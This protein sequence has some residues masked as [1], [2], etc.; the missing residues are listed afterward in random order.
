[1]SAQ[2]PHFSALGRALVQQG[3]LVQADANAI[4]AEAAK[5]GLSFIQQ[6]IQSKKLSAKDVSLFAAQ[7]FGYPLLDLN[8]V[9]VEQLPANLIDA[10]IVTNRRIIPLG[11]RGN[12]VFVGMSDPSNEQV[13]QEVKF[14]TG[15]TMEPIVVEDDKLAVMVRKLTESSA[16]KQID[17]ATEDVDL[18]G[19]EVTDGEAPASEVTTEEIDDAPVVKYVQKI[20]LDAILGGASDIHWEPYEKFYRIRYRTDGI[21]YEIAQPPLAI[22][23]KIASRIKVVSKMDISE[24]R[25]PQDGRMKMVLSKTRAIDFRVSTLPTLFG[26]KIVMRILDPSSATL[27]IDALGY[28]PDQK[29]TC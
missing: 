21:L 16:S 2:P 11:K 27:G 22:K 29:E 7:T 28:D 14:A 13:L 17:I 20:L 23:E 10:K 9:D 24:K 25:V 18:S 8:A 3:K 26:E 15:M 19:I 6:L 5:A 1:M 4:H 12:R